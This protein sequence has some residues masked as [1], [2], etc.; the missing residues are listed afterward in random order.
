LNVIKESDVFDKRPES[1]AVSESTPRQQRSSTKIVGDG[2]PTKR[3]DSNT[4]KEINTN[5]KS[6]DYLKCL[7]IH[8]EKEY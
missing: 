2:H 7:D 1:T 8:I 5:L 4:V 3:K 6:L